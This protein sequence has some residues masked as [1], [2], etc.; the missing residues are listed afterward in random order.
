MANKKMQI[1]GPT[2][3]SKGDL[4]NHAKQI[5][6]SKYYTPDN[7]RKEKNSKTGPI[8]MSFDIAKTTAKLAKEFMKKNNMGKDGLPIKAKSNKKAQIGGQLPKA[9]LGKIVNTVA[10]YISPAVKA[11]KP[12]AKAKNISKE[13]SIYQKQRALAGKP[14][15]R[16][17]SP[18]GNMTMKEIQAKKDLQKAVTKK[19]KKL[20]KEQQ[21]QKDIEDSYRKTG[22]IIKK[23]N[24]GNS[25]FD[26][27]TSGKGIKN[28]G[29][30]N[31][32]TQKGQFS[33]VPPTFE[34]SE[35]KPK[36]NWVSPPSTSSEPGRYPIMSEKKKGGVVKSK[37][38]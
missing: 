12:A 26:K 4:Y 8:G 17:S 10:K 14:V 1:G 30:Q 28:T 5:A 20:T 23:Q 25:G 33:V 36:V 18:K 3:P 19:P 13:L 31:A 16:G 37:K 22:G 9:Q 2:S 27:F 21:Y 32:K 7:I 24:G 38:K 34:V 11:T 15:Y 6:K 29:W 35:K